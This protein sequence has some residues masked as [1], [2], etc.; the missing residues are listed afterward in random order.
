MT[1]IECRSSEDIATDDLLEA[2]T[3]CETA[4]NRIVSNLGLMYRGE[5]RQAIKGLRDSL[6]ARI[7]AGD[8]SLYSGSTYW[9]F[10]AHFTIYNWR[11]A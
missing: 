7:E 3:M 2:H 10:I 5:H 6:A 1:V 8:I 11:A 9:T 4:L